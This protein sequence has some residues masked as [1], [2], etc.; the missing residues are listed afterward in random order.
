MPRSSL[1]VLL[2]LLVAV[3]SSADP[4]P[5]LSGQHGEQWKVPRSP[6]EFHKMRSVAAAEF[7][8]HVSSK[9]PRDS[10]E[11]HRMSAQIKEKLGRIGSNFLGGAKRLVQGL[12]SAAVPIG[13]LP[14]PANMVKEHTAMAAWW[15]ATP[16]HSET[17]ACRKK[18]SSERLK[19]AP[20]AAERQKLLKEQPKK[21]TDAAGQR[22]AV[23]E[24]QTM[25]RQYC[26]KVV[27][28]QETSLCKT[29]W[30]YDVL[31]RSSVGALLAGLAN[32]TRP[33][34]S[35]VRG[36]PKPQPPRVTYARR[37]PAPAGLDADSR[38]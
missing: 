38:A 37:P 17:Y 25:L 15:C 2:A 7:K 29:S 6:A 23:E 34:V 3:A 12:A 33:R 28:A 36:A 30:S 35:S 22:R 1:V 27:A 21:P 32:S 16:N 11:L 20:G 4:V 13:P 5:P 9:V 10:A 8:E 24:V 18:S 31:K 14:S 26:T 19:T